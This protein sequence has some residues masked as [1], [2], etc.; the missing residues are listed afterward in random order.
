MLV[1]HSHRFVFL[2]EM[3]TASTSTEFALSDLCRGPHD[4]IGPMDDPQRVEVRN[5]FDLPMSKNYTRPPHTWSPS[6]LFYSTVISASTGRPA[7]RPL[8]RC[9]EVPSVVRAAIGRRRFEEYTK[10]S[11]LRNPFDRVLSYAR[12]TRNPDEAPLTP[13]SFGKWF[14]QTKTTLE[15]R[16]TRSRYLRGVDIT[17]RYLRF[18]TLVGDLYLLCKE[19]SWSTRPAEILE[20]LHLKSFGASKTDDGEFFEENPKIVGWIRSRFEKDFELG[21]YSI[22][23]PR[24]T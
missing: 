9:H 17:D 15:F 3:K 18:E 7:S 14:E 24:S 16:L 4:I 6:A 5:R 8:Y 21:A 10:I 19:Y 20:E 22:D 12:W 11:T 13:D 2:R 23:I 1:S